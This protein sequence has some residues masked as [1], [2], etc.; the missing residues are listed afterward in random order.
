MVKHKIDDFIEAVE[1]THQAFAKATHEVLNTSGY[2]MKIES[3]ASGLFVSYSHP[4]T[5]RSIL[6]FLFRKSGLLVRLYIDNSSSH[7]SM[8]DLP[9]SME[10]EINKAPN[11]KMCSEKCNKGNKFLMRGQAYDKCRYNAFLFAVTEESKP[12]LTKWIENEVKTIDSSASET[13]IL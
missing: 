5:K 10:K 11:C 7:F 2:K 6:N 1:P 8:D 13:E 9:A 12:I 4:K 3:K